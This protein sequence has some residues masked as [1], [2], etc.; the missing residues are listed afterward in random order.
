MFDAP[1]DLDIAGRIG[2]GEADVALY[3]GDTLKDGSWLI[4]FSFAM[5]CE[6]RHSL[7]GNFTLFMKVEKPGDRRVIELD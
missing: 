5:P 1:S 3:R 6:L 7:T 2:V 4:H